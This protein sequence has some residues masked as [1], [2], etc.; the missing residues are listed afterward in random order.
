MYH[1]AQSEIQTD[2]FGSIM[3]LHQIDHVGGVLL[4]NPDLQTNSC[5]NRPRQSIRSSK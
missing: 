3:R 4:V 5:R 2:S 1:I